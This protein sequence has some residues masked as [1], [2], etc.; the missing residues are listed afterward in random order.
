MIGAAAPLLVAINLL[1]LLVALLRLD[2]E[3]CDRA[4]LEPL[5]RDRLA[6]FLAIAVG[7]VVDA[8]DG[9][10]DLGDQLALAVTRA[11]F[12]GAV[13]LRGRAVGEV[14]MID[15]L[16]LQLDQRRLRLAQYF[17]F[18]CEQLGAEIIALTLVHERLLLRGPIGLLLL[19]HRHREL[20]PSRR[21]KGSPRAPLI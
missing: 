15:V 19:R 6:G 9:G 20:S 7:A 4:R 12:D 17:L 1:A 8:A 5:Q 16:V 11:Q 14:W 21:G 2:R 13:G 10:V 18:P 3:R